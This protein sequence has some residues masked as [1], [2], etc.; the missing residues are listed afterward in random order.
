[1]PRTRRTQSGDP[2]MST[3]TGMPGVRYGEGVQLQQLQQ[4]M[5]TP[6]ARAQAPAG[7]PSPAPAGA[8]QPAPA[9]GVDPMS[10]PTPGLLLAPTTRA[11]EPI[12]AGLSRGLG[13]GPEILAQNPIESPTGKFLRDLARITGRERFAELARRSNL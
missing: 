9:V 5:P 3:S 13:P 6:N 7:A 12:T 2:A 11:N 8:G 1:M 10:M 4:A